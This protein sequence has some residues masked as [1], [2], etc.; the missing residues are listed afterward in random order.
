MAL[1]VDSLPVDPRVITVW[2]ESLKTV[3]LD[4]LQDFAKN[5]KHLNAGFRLGKVNRTILVARIVAMLD[6]TKELSTDLCALLR[7]ATLSRQLICVLSEEFI[8]HV[9]PQ[10]ADAYGRLEFFAGLLLDEREAMRLIG[11]QKVESWSGINADDAEQK[12]AFKDLQK[13]CP[14]FLTHMT[15]PP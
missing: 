1:T 6:Q 8:K 3:D 10:L 14:R 11:H 5:H 4:L 13:L 2:K 9:L 15:C 7:D 12:Q